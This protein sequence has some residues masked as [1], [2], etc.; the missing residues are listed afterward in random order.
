MKVRNKKFIFFDMK[1]IIIPQDLESEDFGEVTRELV[2]Q[3]AVL[4]PVICHASSVRHAFDIYQEK[5]SEHSS[6]INENRVIKVVS[7]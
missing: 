2:K 3:K 7:I 1:G 5:I 4:I 6:F